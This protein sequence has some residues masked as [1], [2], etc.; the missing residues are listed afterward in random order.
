VI[1]FKPRS[2]YP[3]G[4]DFL[5]PLDRRLGGPQK[6]YGKPDKVKVNIPVTGLGG[7]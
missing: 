1:I 2:L 4:K 5:Y 3:R 7:L 6:R